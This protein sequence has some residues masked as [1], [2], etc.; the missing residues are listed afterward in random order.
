M[1]DKPNKKRRGKPSFAKCKVLNRLNFYRALILPL[2]LG[3][4]CLRTYDS[5]GSAARS[6]R[7]GNCFLS[8]CTC[9]VPSFISFIH[10]QPACLPLEPCTHSTRYKESQNIACFSFLFEQEYQSNHKIKKR[11]EKPAV[12]LLHYVM[13]I[14]QENSK[15]NFTFCCC[16]EQK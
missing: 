16:V 9:F 13:L 1:L 8:A 12:L 7:V 3:Q 15:G 11:K 14:R 6:L 2:L 5:T 4:Y 10:L